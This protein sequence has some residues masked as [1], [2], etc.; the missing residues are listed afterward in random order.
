MKEGTPFFTITAKIPVVE[1]FGFSDDIRKKTSGA[2]LPQL[3]FSGFEIIDEDPFWVP[4]TEEEL[5]ALGEFAE[6]E[7]IARKYM[8]TIRKKKGLFVDEKVIKNAEKQRTLKKD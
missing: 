3:V 7:N 8:N 6:R 2:A 4:T 5:E 1:A